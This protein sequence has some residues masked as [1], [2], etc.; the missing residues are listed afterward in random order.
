MKQ[1]KYRAAVEIAGITPMIT[2]KCGLIK[3]GELNNANTDYSDEWK[4]KVYSN[5]KGE[6]VIPSIILEA[7]LFGA[8][9]GEKIGKNFLTR[10]IASGCQV[11]EFDVPMYNGKKMMKDDIEKNNWL[12]SC[13]VVVGGKRV[14]R[15]RPMYPVGWKAKFHVLVYD[16]VFIKPDTLKYLIEKAGVECGLGDWRPS[17]KKPGKFGQFEVS[18]FELVK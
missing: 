15:T 5:D 8:S 9:K 16:D 14:M 6:C 12:F 17:A 10:K 3:K 13:P 1:I 18:K 7:S 11:E 2:N 4:E